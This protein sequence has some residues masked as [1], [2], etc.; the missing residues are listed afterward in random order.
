MTGGGLS[1]SCDQRFLAR[2]LC[3]LH[4]CVSFGYISGSAFL[5]SVGEAVAFK[6]AAVL[7][8]AGL[9]QAGFFWAA[10]PWP[11]PLKPPWEL[12]ASA[13]QSTGPQSSAIS[14]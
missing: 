7:G 1:G 14:L 12:C 10:E 2:K 9:K 13:F 4:P 6:A 11:E 8:H 5:H 3:F